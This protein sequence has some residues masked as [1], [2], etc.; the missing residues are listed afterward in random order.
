MIHAPWFKDVKVER[1]SGQ[2]QYNL[3]VP[4]A[5]YN[6]Y[7][8][9]RIGKHNIVFACLPNYEYG[10]ASCAIIAAQLLSR[11]NASIFLA[12]SKGTTFV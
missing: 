3:P 6:T 10:I 9:G 1:I 2:V 4:P 7:T 11:P 5:H 8:L 12:V